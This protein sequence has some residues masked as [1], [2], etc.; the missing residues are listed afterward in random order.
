[1]NS[2]WSFLQ[3]SSTN[4]STNYRREVCVLL[5]AVSM[6]LQAVGQSVVT[7][8]AVGTVTDP[9][10][11]VVSGATVTL[12][13]SDTG[14]TQ[15]VVTGANGFYRFALLKPGQYRLTV[16]QT[17]FKSTS[18]T[19]LVSV[20]Q[21][22]TAN[23]TL[24]LGATSEV[25]EVT[26]APPLIET[27][28]ANL[29]TTYS[30][31][32]LQQL[33]VPGGD[34]TSYAYSA[35][36]VTMN[37]AAGYGNFSS[38]GLPSTSNLFTTNGNDNMYVY[39]NVNN[40]GASNL[41]LGANE[42]DQI[43]IVQNG[44]TAQYGRQAG[45]QMNA[46]TKSGTNS[47]HG[48]ASYWWNGSSLNANDWFGN[49]AGTPR[50]FANSNQWA[51]SLGGPIVKNKLFFFA[52][53][54]GLRF[55]LPGSSGVQY[56]PTPAF[57]TFVQNNIAANPATAATLPWYQ[58][59]FTLYA[60]APGASRATPLTAADDS[61]LG[62][63]D[64]AG[65]AGFGTSTPCAMKFTSNQNNLN[66]EWLLTTR[67]DYNISNKDQLFGR[68]KTDHGVQAT[69]TDPINPVFNADSIQPQYE[70]QINETHVFGSG[71][72]N[73][74]IVS[75]S[76]A[77]SLFTANDLPA[78]LKA[79][80]TTMIFN[81][82]LLTD[83]GG[84]GFRNS[85]ASA[86]NNFPQGT[87]VTQYQIVD[88]LS[89]TKGPHELKFGINFRRDLVSDY[90][91]GVNTSGTFSINSMTEFVNGISSG[92]SDLSQR[93]RNVDQVRI[94][95][96]SLGLYAQD[97]W[98]ATS[99][100]AVTGAIRI[101][102]NSNPTCGEHCFTRFTSPF[103]ALSHDPNQPYNAIIGTGL[104]SALP[105]IQPLVISPRLGLA[106]NVHNNTVIRGGIGL[107]T[108]LY[109]AVIVDRFLT[110]A[111]NVST[112][113][114][115]SGLIATDLNGA[116]VPGSL[117]DA[118]IQSNAAFQAGFANGATLADLQAATPL[119]TPPTFN[120][121]GRK[122]LNPKFLE[123]NLE[124]EQQLGSKSSLSVNY[125]GNHGYD[126]MTDNPFDNAFCNSTGV[127]RGCSDATP[128]GGVITPTQPDQRFAQVRTLTNAGWSNY[129]GLTASFKYRA[130]KSLQAQFNYTWSHA[131]D[132]CSNNCLL[133]FSNST[134]T[135]IRYQVSPTLPGTAY[136][137]S[138][139]DVRHN[140]TA[141]YLYTTPTNF[142][143]SFLK[144]A[145][146]NWTVAGTIYYH[147][148]YPWTPV[149]TGVR[150]SLGN[151]VGLR[152]A[153]PVAEFAVDPSTLSC[154]NPNSPCAT[155]ADFVPAASQ[156]GF[157]N[158]PRNTLRGPKFFDTDM[159]V[160]KYIPITERVKFAV[161]ASLF[162]LFNHPN[163]DLPLN[164]VGGGFGSIVNTVSPATNPYGSFLSV[165]LT[166]RIVQLNARVTF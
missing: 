139:Y 16:K 36:G 76:W 126:V 56:L 59:V 128:F 106:Y 141:N 118:N 21:I 64:F 122:L 101:D 113:D 55:V 1:M 163:F 78:A 91:T 84:G 81:D 11:A 133:P 28:N 42:L 30:T 99:K 73:Q 107:F 157:G 63:G 97:Q 125:V 140:F 70:G 147:T 143:H 150:S 138:D 41:S 40:S 10:G 12:T 136:S 47:F 49:N 111:P 82:G 39:L 137:N 116:V 154:S 158:F 86:D 26:G 88:D 98:R 17:G 54:E 43:S 35:P 37:N 65:T 75:G 166:G 14:A 146:G 85:T 130:T 27:E 119:F 135:S 83:L 68:F 44:Y 15:F 149:S 102:R 5:I 2:F 22:T 134:E 115:N 145:V 80:P 90:T 62:C 9:S 72:V 71:G 87:I 13:S 38:Y 110:N 112:F 77:S 114:A 127:S 89:K 61:A 121:I 108:D 52:D 120:D 20:G 165:P 162:N 161:G 92:N 50:P 95:L 153:T 164:N 24:E 69:G 124:V 3:D 96:Y 117:N 45:A 46:T 31:N 32:Q 156:T 103:A 155:T 142:S 53:Q 34:I 51:A 7:G 94:K 8:D 132:T 57:A 123:W 93:F 105:N 18:Q 151:V 129:H 29:A 23:V 152:S 104:G 74:L 79:F 131:L 159:N 109:P 6:A 58:N 19:L 60:G 33:P 67:I 4:K 144:H 100:L 160:T 48:N 148:G 66:T 25:V